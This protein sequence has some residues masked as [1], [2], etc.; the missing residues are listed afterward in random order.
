[1]DWNKIVWIWIYFFIGAGGAIGTIK[2]TE[3]YIG[4]LF[5]ILERTIKI[6]SSELK[7]LYDENAALE[8]NINKLK[9]KRSSLESRNHELEEILF[10]RI[11]QEGAI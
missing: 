1:M 6:R 10:E 7:N 11:K 9:E 4:K 2:L 5:H 3:S 8:S